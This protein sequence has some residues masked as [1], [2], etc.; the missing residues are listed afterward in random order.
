MLTCCL[1][2]HGFQMPDLVAAVLA[3][4]EGRRIGGDKPNIMLDGQ[5]LIDR[6]VDHVLAWDIPAVMVVRH[7]EQVLED[8]LVQILDQPDIEGPLGGLIA[9][10]EWGEHS[11]AERLITIPCD[12]P[13][14]PAD[15]KT[16]LDFAAAQFAR[17]AVA[18][19]RQRR[20]PVCSVWPISSL[21]ALQFYA[22]RGARSLNGALELCL[23]TEV[24]WPIC[25]IDP[26]CNINTLGDLDCAREVSAKGEASAL[27]RDG[28]QFS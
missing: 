21:K 5:R 28:L 6:A 3:G 15:L 23:A 4:G 2:V 22:R 9:A 7:R 16:R 1:A 11:H 27:L 12:M 17:P 10:L 25:T 24:D 8:R 19:S 20:H 13:H 26:F 14:L 18:R